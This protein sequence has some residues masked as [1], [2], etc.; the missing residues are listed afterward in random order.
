MP[1]RKVRFYRTGYHLRGESE[2]V[3]N[4][5]S[6]SDLGDGKTSYGKLLIDAWNSVTPNNARAQLKDRHVIFDKATVHNRGV[7]V[8]HARAGY[9]GEPGEFVDSKTG[10]LLDVDVDGTKTKRGAL[11]VAYVPSPYEDISAF[12][13]VEYTPNGNIFNNLQGIFRDALHDFDPGLTVVF[14]SILTGQD[15]I[16]H[17]AQLQQIRITVDA[18]RSGVDDKGQSDAEQYRVEHVMKPPRGQKYFAPNIFE[19]LRRRKVAPEAI[20]RV[21][22]PDDVDEE[23]IRYR[24]QLGDGKQS[25]LMDLEK[26][27]GVPIYEVISESNEPLKTDEEFAQIAYE[28]VEEY[29]K[30]LE[31]DGFN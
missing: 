20:M 12:Y 27:S 26:L 14:E 31:A 7:I 3:R 21:S 11:R 6:L 4:W 13:L 24:V 23:E 1:E 19:S 8:V 2:A 25:R 18:Q 17:Q 28:R 22:V 16:E 30:S 15:W 9:I 10:K 5:L 29:Y